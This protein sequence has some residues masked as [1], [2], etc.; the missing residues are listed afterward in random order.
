M[1][2]W[3]SIVE[4]GLNEAGTI[5][6]IIDQPAQCHD[7]VIAYANQPFGLLMRQSVKDLSG[8]NLTVL[9]DRIVHADCREQLLQS[10]RTA[11]PAQFDLLLSA[12]G[13]ESWLG[14]RLSFL[15]PDETGALSAIMIGRDITQARKNARQDDK[16]RQLLAQI[17]MRINAPVAILGRTGSMVM[18][19][20]A[21]RQLTGYSND[22]V[23]NLRVE[24]LTP[25][26][27]VEAMAAAR[28][29]QFADGKRFE[30]EFET[31][32][33]G[34]QR[35]AVRLTSDLL[36]TAD[37]AYRVVTLIQRAS[38]D[39]VDPAVQKELH[40]ALAARDRGELRVLSLE[41]LRVSFGEAWERLALRAMMR[42]EQLIRKRLKREDVLSRA[43][44]SNFLIWF[45]TDDRNVSKATLEIIVRDIR[46][47]FLSEFGEELARNISSTLVPGLSPAEPEATAPALPVPNRRPVAVAVHRP[48]L[49]NPPKAPA[50]V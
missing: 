9:L 12:N 38:T 10:L 25:P 2:H 6:A 17:F 20:T 28:E 37:D 18:C 50:R 27:F 39:R 21:F 5:V 46:L 49:W 26:D 30:L 11:A 41:A 47:A 15:A 35:A 33:K 8:S 42:A 14:M 22:E 31:L 19:N 29:A 43:D 40:D 23:K 4:A 7:A 13:V 3:S 32:V 36:S 44:D 16:M 1:R 45:S 48:A 24:D 34:G